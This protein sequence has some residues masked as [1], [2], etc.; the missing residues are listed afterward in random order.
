MEVK[1]RRRYNKEFKEDVINML[2]TGDKSV[3]TLSRELE[4]AEAIIYRWYKQ[5][6]G[7][8]G[9]EPEKVND[10]EKEIRELRKQLAEITEE[11]NILK[12][13]VSIFSKQGKLK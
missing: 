6:Q 2:R 4:I 3:A 5:S 1:K 7:N 8:K 11:R 13:A 10:Q 12:K 9:T